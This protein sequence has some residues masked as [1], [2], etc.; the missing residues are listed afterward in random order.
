[1]KN[2]KGTGGFLALAIGLLALVAIALY[3]IN[4]VFDSEQPT[5]PVKTTQPAI[6]N[7][8]QA[9]QKT[10]DV[11]KGLQEASANIEEIERKIG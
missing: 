3:M 2:K 10:A 7:P 8:Q 4:F 6:T 1:M 11:G 5:V 9:S